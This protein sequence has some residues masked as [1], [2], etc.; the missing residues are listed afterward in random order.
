MHL[1]GDEVVLCILG[2]RLT[3]AETTV[4]RVCSPPHLSKEL[5]PYRSWRW[6]SSKIQTFRHTGGDV[7]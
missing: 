6:A 7:R 5:L 2:A 1:D 4:H 3:R